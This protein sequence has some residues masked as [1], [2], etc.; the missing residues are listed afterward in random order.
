MYPV[1]ALKWIIAEL[2]SG[3]PSGPGGQA[4]YSAQWA[5]YYRSM[6]MIRE[7]ESIE[8]QQKKPPQAQPNPPQTQSVITFRKCSESFSKSFS[9]AQTN[10][11]LVTSSSLFLIR[12]NNNILNSSYM[13][14]LFYWT[15]CCMHFARIYY[16][17]VLLYQ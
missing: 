15:E 12:Y 9:I 8:Q 5:E 13:P 14:Y 11:S 10:D 6:G 7:A 3:G 16:I 17:I 1:S 2:L 4:D